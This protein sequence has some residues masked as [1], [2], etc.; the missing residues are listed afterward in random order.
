MRKLLSAVCFA[1]KIVR[2]KSQYYAEKMSDVF[3]DWV[4][5][6]I[7][8]ITYS[9]IMGVWILLHRVGVLSLDTKDFLVWSMFAGYFSGIQASMVLMSSS[10]IASRDREKVSRILQMV[11]T[12]EE[13]VDEFTE[14][15]E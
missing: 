7:F 12:L 8:V 14:E 11:V 15:K 5:T 9:L 6:W 10:R 3:S 1:F 2:I 4:G 13:M